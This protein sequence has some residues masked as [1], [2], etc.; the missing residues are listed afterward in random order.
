MQE[1]DG[2]Q[3]TTRDH[4][5]TSM[6]LGAGDVLSEIRNQHIIDDVIE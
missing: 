2:S 5:H 4:I 3:T 1:D 6:T